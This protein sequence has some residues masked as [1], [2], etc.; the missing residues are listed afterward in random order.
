MLNV[1]VSYNGIVCI[2]PW[3]SIGIEFVSSLLP[4]QLASHWCLNLCPYVTFTLDQAIRIHML[5]AVYV[6]ICVFFFFS[7]T[8]ISLFFFLSSF[9]DIRMQTQMDTM[10]LSCSC[11]L[12]TGGGLIDCP[13]GRIH[14]MTCKLHSLP[15]I[16]YISSEMWHHLWHNKL[17]HWNKEPISGVRLKRKFTLINCKAELLMSLGV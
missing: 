2:G 6:C 1:L 5:M 3:K 15:L 16:L 10:T 9:M 13:I 8:L 17:C 14:W 7:F 12:C 11:L 4:A